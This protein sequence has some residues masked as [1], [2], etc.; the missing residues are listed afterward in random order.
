MKKSLQ[1]RLLLLK[2]LVAIKYVSLFFS[3]FFFISF[4]IVLSIS[5]A[6]DLLQLYGLHLDHPYLNLVLALFAVPSMEDLVSPFLDFF[7][8]SH[9]ILF[10]FF[11]GSNQRPQVSLLYCL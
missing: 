6:C 9:C 5:L 8:Y 7:S 10:S 11:L 1:P 2:S 3:F 4:L